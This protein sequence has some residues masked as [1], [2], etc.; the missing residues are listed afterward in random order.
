MFLKFRT[1]SAWAIVQDV[2]TGEILAMASYPTF[3]PVEYNKVDEDGEEIE[4]LV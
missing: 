2:Q 4:L 1:K 3:N